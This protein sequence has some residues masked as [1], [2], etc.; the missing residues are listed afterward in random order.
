MA[1]TSEDEVITGVS[2]T[3]TPQTTHDS[4]HEVNET[5]QDADVPAHTDPDT[6]DGIA[7]NMDQK[8][9]D[10]DDGPTQ[11]PQSQTKSSSI[12]GGRKP[13]KRSNSILEEVRALQDRLLQ[14]EQQ[15]AWELGGEAER[16]GSDEDGKGALDSN[17]EKELRNHVRRAHFASKWVKKTEEHAAQTLNE[18]SRVGMGPPYMHGIRHMGMNINP[19]PEFTG[20]EREMCESEIRKQRYGLRPPTSLR[21]IYSGKL[22]P[23]SQ[24]DMS[25]YD[26]WSSD[27]SITSRDFD[28]FRT[29]LRGDFEW[30]LH[31][32]TRQRERYKKHKEKK[33]TDKARGVVTPSLPGETMTNASRTPGQ[34]EVE[35]HAIAKLSYLEWDM[36]RTV[37]KVPTSM[38]SAIDILIGEPD[39]S[40]D[41]FWGRSKSSGAKLKTQV[42]IEAALKQPTT[43]TTY[44]S[45]QEPLPERIRIH[46]KQL[47]KTL[48][49]I[50]G[51]E[52][53]V[54]MYR[55]NDV[56]NL[57]IVML[58]PFRMLTYYYEKLQEWH[59]KILEDI[60][61]AKHTPDKNADSGIRLRETTATAAI[62]EDTEDAKSV[63][64]EEGVVK[65]PKGYSTSETTLEHLSCLFEFMDKYVVEKQAYLRGQNYGEIFFSDIWHLFKPGDI[66]IAANGKQAYQVVNINSSRHRGTDR[67]AAFYKED[68]NSDKK[69]KHEEIS[70][71]CVYIH[72]DGENLGPV[73]KWFSIRKFD[74]RKTITTLP[75]YPL[76][77][78]VLRNMDPRVLKSKPDG[79]ELEEA[80]T[81]GVEELRQSLIDRGRLF[82][83][84]AGVKH[85][86]YA[87]LTVGT[88][89]E[90]ES[91]VMIDFEEAFAN[92]ASWRPEITRFVGAITSDKSSTSS[93][94]DDDECTASCCIG[95][96]VHD[97]SYV[98]SKRHEDFIN[99]SM[100]EIQDNPHR[101]PSAAIFPRS[102]EDIKTDDNALKEDE[103]LIMSYSVFGF[104]LRDRTWAEF[105]LTYLTEVT[106]GAEASD[107]TDDD[108]ADEDDRSAFG[109]LVLPKGHK[110]MVLSLISQHFRNKESQKH[111]DE[112]VDIVRGKG[113]GLIIL[114][115]GAPGVGKTTTAEGVAERFKK[116]LFQI[117]CGD[118]GTDAKGV[119]A[120]LQTNFSL[121]NKWDCILLL[122]EADVFLAE[123]RREDFTRNGLVAVFLR[124]LEYYGGILFLTTNR[125]GDFDEAFASRI[126]MSLHYPP[127]DEISTTKVFRLN[128]GLIRARYKEKGRKI[129]IDEDEIL[130]IMGEYWRTRKHA[131][132][133]GR[134][135]RNA[136]QTALALAEF[137]AQPVGHK[138]DLK[139]VES[140]VKVHL[141]EANLQTVA[142]AYLEFIEYLRAVHGADADTYAKEAGVRALETVIATLKSGKNIAGEGH[143]TGEDAGEKENPLHSFKIK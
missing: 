126:H 137:D 41:G 114:L 70:I 13:T 71:Q 29:R 65:D 32:L 120:A 59:S 86:Y 129:K 62:E 106:S 128:L 90:I 54:D 92:N 130:K 18:P 51:L 12:E 89:D 47:I 116:P 143:S 136:C 141:T 15:A 49:V 53:H 83:D 131:R 79:S 14:L 45:A 73:S 74:G 80:I 127:L 30:E 96:V 91:Q 139:P 69:S 142:N 16:I 19:F 2:D 110:D 66:A 33:Q 104:V 78:H 11:Q 132:W 25:D 56:E 44:N 40:D 109:R 50:R 103:L 21:P 64:D 82:I 125:I 67:W 58:R 95:E 105:D 123:R 117:T 107:T 35:R 115:H 20:Q 17:D 102:L 124:V 77:F 31:R 87:G 7:L 10:T 93:V 72:F 97:D 134:Q 75:V 88:R 94:D 8:P 99:N 63:Q 42:Q 133:N 9:E 22:G 98:E 23:P 28:Y 68:K 118:L 4:S 5:R 48:S 138:Y 100:A 140:N 60:R 43:R 112:Q 84:V 101:L 61:Q 85:M 26:E 81:N 38:S 135:I 122:D 111:K 55:L 108:E 121:A 34:E 3:P 27:E 57:S 37:R 36:F 1:S 113:K 6:K 39:I 76:R 46:S 119:E 24:W 52:L